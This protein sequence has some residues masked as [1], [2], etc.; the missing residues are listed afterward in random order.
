MAMTEKERNV[1]AKVERAVFNLDNAIDEANA[2]KNQISRNFNR[3]IAEGSTP[4]FNLDDFNSVLEP[5][6]DEFNHLIRYTSAAVKALAI[7]PSQDD[8]EEILAVFKE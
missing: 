5:V 8:I 4:S 7:K 3:T 6:S 2:I 1:F